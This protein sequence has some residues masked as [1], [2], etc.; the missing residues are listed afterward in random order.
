MVLVRD[1]IS[2]VPPT[3]A[4]A[5]LGYM[6][7]LAFCPVG[8][9]SPTGRINPMIRLNEKK[10]VDFIDIEDLGDKT[11]LCRC[12]KSKTVRTKFY[13]FYFVQLWHI[14]KKISY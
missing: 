6:S 8:R 3:A 4:L 11:V 14:V 7:Y 5:G 1:W 12:W 2:L 10:V 9:P 13:Y